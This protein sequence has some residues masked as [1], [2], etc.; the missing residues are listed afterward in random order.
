VAEQRDT[1]PEA[2]NTAEVGT[3]GRR[4]RRRLWWT[5]AAVGAGAAFVAVAVLA[6]NLWV[7]W[8]G[9]RGNVASVAEAPTAQ[10]A[11]VLGARAWGDRPSPMLADRLDVGIA[12][13]RAGKV[14][15]LLLS[16][17][18]GTTSYDEVKAMRAYVLARGIPPADVFTDHAG[19]STYDTMY[20]ARDVF[21]V[22]RALVVTQGF[23]LA[24]AVYTARALGLTVTGVPADQHDYPGV[25]FQLTVRDWLARVKAALQLHV[26]HAK[27]RFLGPPIPI[28]GDGRTS[29]G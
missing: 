29:L 19:F 4:R 11:I 9:G 1:E 23:H 6:T 7:V 10:V 2:V 8:Q 27:P 26:L 15:K 12:L 13:Y 16:G 18:H 22:E 28:T 24:R 25:T 20:R 14:P 21:R 5:A 17:D 3:A